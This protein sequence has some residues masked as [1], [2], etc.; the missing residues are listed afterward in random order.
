MRF[1][2]VLGIGGFFSLIFSVL[3]ALLQMRPEE[4]ETRAAEWLAVAGFPELGEGLTLTTDAWVTGSLAALV[5]AS[6]GLVCFGLF[7]I[8][9]G[10]RKY[11]TQDGPPFDIPIRTA[12]EHYVRTFPHSYRE[13]ADQHAFETLHKAMCNGKLPVVGAKGEDSHSERIP[14]R[15]CKRLKPAVVVV[16]RNRATP[17]GVRFDL[18]EE[19]GE[20]EPLVEHD[21]FSGYTGLCVRS[22]DLYR[23]WPKDLSGNG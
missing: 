12:V 15:K 1:I 5:F 19:V 21:G 16:P 6:F 10:A 22:S 20:I 7:R 4:V 23:L 3:L 2:V 9:R 17:R 14:A 8:V 13:G 11:K 18:M